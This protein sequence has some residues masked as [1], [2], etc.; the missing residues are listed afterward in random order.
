MFGRLFS[1]G[2]SNKPPAYQAGQQ[3]F[4]QGM[5]AASEYRTAEAMSL[6][7]K[8]FEINPNPAPL[9]NRAKL[10][11]W[12]LLF[13]EAI[14]DLE[15]AKRLDQQQ[16]NE[17]SVVLGKELVE[18]RMLA[19]NRFNGKREL[20]IADLKAKGF[21]YVAGR[22]ADSIFDGNGQMLGYHLVYEVDNV[23]KFENIAD[24][25]SVNT[26]LKNWMKD[27]R[28]I[29]QTLSS[30][31]FS[32]TYREKREVFE[33]MICVYDYTDMA[34][35]RDVI[36]RKIWCLLNPPSQM[37]SLWEASLRQPIS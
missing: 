6:Y 34:K 17:F 4:Q 30:P 20:F 12:R 9:I 26:L 14:Q 23:K 24:F 35:M 21:D 1:G 3:L 13:A 37:Q 11:R 10:Y 16:G 29:D 8:S 5:E 25:P 28:V 18:C 15:T 36:V 22:F 31:S 19:Q 7:T 32:R 27:Q 33:A 2:N